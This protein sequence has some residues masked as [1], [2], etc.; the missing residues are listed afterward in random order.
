MLPDAIHGCHGG[1]GSLEG[2]GLEERGG[3]KDTRDDSHRAM[4]EDSGGKYVADLM[5]VAVWRL[6]KGSKSKSS[7][8]Y[9]GELVSKEAMDLMSGGAVKLWSGEV[10]RSFSQT[11]AMTKAIMATMEDSGETLERIPGG[12]LERTYGETLERTCYS[13]LQSEGCKKG[14]ILKSVN[15]PGGARERRGYGSREWRGCE[16]LERSGDWSFA[17][18]ITALCKVPMEGSK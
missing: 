18:D 15:L 5:S 8:S 7:R 17:H 4:V 1:A 10:D 9:Q 12:T 14:Q 3:I 2:Q 13:V 6:Q 11:Q 16:A